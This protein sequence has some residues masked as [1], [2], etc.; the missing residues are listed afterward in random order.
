MD[1]ES[2]FAG[3]G[4]DYCP[5]QDAIGSIADKWK[6]LILIELARAGVLRFKELQRALGTV[7]QKVLTSALRDLERDGLVSRRVY[8]EVPPRVEYRPT[9]RAGKLLPVLAQ[10]QQWAEENPVPDRAELTASAAAR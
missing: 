5:M 4:P 9:A 7:S 3:F 10:L 8:A 2:A 1:V 6:L